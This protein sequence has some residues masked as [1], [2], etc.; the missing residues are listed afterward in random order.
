M[1]KNLELDGSS[2]HALQS[3]TER[4]IAIFDEKPYLASHVRL[5]ELRGFE[6]TWPEKEGIYARIAEGVIQRLSKMDTIEF[7]GVDWKRLSPSLRAAL[8]GAFEALSL[9]RITITKCIFPA[10]ADLASL[11]IHARYLKALAIWSVFF[12]DEPIDEPNASDFVAIPRSIKLDEFGTSEID[13]FT[14][15]F[16]EESCPFEIG[17][18][19]FLRIYFSTPYHSAAFLVQ[20]VGPNLRKLELHPPSP[21]KLEKSPRESLAAITSQ[22]VGRK[23][24][25]VMVMGARVQAAVAVES[26]RAV[27]AAK[28][29]EPTRAVAGARPGTR[30]PAT[31]GTPN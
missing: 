14:S 28:V 4:I 30:T 25:M 21:G 10:F 29:A 6:S 1:F 26:T 16:Q 9:T 8:F 20:H 13:R 23:M 12:I 7:N 15:W 11:L 24:R 17:D 3:K 19:Q 18:L 22:N 27:V 5:L 2:L 31:R